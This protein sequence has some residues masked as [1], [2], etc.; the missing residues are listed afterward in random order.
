M[1]EPAKGKPR[2][3]RFNTT[4]PLDR[5]SLRAWVEH[6]ANG[7][8]E[9]DA[10]EITLTQDESEDGRRSRRVT[11]FQVS[12]NYNICPMRH[13]ERDDPNPKPTPK[14]KPGGAGSGGS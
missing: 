8:T 6:F 1:A 10:V 13:G 4:T 9:N 11:S 5:E 2:A 12:P 7:L 3:K 14:P